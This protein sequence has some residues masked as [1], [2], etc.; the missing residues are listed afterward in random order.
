MSF[1]SHMYDR[2]ISY[3]LH[4]VIS[5]QFPG[6]H[7]THTQKISCQWVSQ[8]FIQITESKEY[9]FSFD[10]LVVCC[11]FLLLLFYFVYLLLF[12][13][14]MES[15]C[16]FSCQYTGVGTR[17][18]SPTVSRAMSSLLCSHWK[19]GS[20]TDWYQ[21]RPIHSEAPQ[22]CVCVCGCEAADS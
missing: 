22:M 17:H 15:K 14:I 21:I 19:T 7:S 3:T 11:C 2:R 4:M 5:E 6:G 20:S 1:S 9:N 13:L 10:L 18:N 16:T 12:L 8:T